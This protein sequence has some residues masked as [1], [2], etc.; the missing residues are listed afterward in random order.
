VNYSKKIEKAIQT[1]TYLHRNQ[2]RRGTGIPYVSHLFAVFLILSKYTKN[3][4]ILIA[5]LL[6]DSLE[7]S[8]PNDYN[9]EKLKQDFGENVLTIVQGV[10][11]DKDGS[12]SEKDAKLSWRYRK[13]SYLHHLNVVS[14]ESVLVSTA[15]KIHN[16]GSTVE[17]LKKEGD[18]IWDK[19]NASKEDQMWFYE[20]FNKIVK[21][22]TANPIVNEFAVLLQEINTLKV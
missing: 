22:K 1:A 20:S 15:D 19:F 9:K 7:D 10:S 3:E 8:D 13:E 14:E 4:D 18:S 6:H 17:D 12:L 16:L 5:G 21:Q 2:T 11:E